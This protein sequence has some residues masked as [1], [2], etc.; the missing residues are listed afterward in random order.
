MIII[1]GTLH[2]DRHTFLIISRFILLRMRNVSDKSFRENQNTHFAFNIFFFLP[3]SRAVYEIMWNNV[4]KQDT[5]L[6][7]I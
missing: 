7:T 2:E 6:T 1:T 5:L 3:L 4:V